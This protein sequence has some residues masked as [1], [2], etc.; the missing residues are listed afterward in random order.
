MKSILILLAGIMI[1]G[2]LI[3]LQYRSLVIWQADEIRAVT[4]EKA[5][6]SGSLG[7]MSIELE[8]HQRNL[9]RRKKE[10]AILRQAI[11]NLGLADHLDVIEKKLTLRKGGS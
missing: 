5:L 7:Q 6:M 4:K 9:D 2:E 11:K 1:G 3:S 10:E 8:M